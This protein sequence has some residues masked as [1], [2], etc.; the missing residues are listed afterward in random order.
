MGL[1]ETL[2]EVESEHIRAAVV[3]GGGMLSDIAVDLGIPKSTLASKLKRNFP[4]LLALAT[5]LREER[6][7]GRG[8]PRQEKDMRSKPAVIAEWDKSGRQYSVCAAAL[9]IPAS[10]C[11]DLVMRYGLPEQYPPKTT[12]ESRDAA[13]ALAQERRASRVARAL[14]RAAELS[15]KKTL[16]RNK[17]KNDVR[18]GKR[19]TIAKTKTKTATKK[20]RKPA[21]KTVKKKAKA[22][23][24]KTAKKTRKVA[25]PTV[26]LVEQIVEQPM[27]WE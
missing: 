24:K 17:R 22:P 6:G 16:A 1:Q 27:D 12:K 18:R 4:D 13:R 8:R 14:E 11:R 10:T 3:R 15:E 20:T 23:A 25:N 21:K 26:V 2:S 9:G 19:Q 7:D 5:S